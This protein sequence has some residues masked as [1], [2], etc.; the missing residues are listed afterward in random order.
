LA[1]CRG[2]A[3]GI[4]CTVADGTNLLRRCSTVAGGSLSAAVIT[5]RDSC[6]LQRD[7]QATEKRIQLRKL[8]LHSR[9]VFDATGRLQVATALGQVFGTQLDARFLPSDGAFF[10]APS[11]RA[12][13]A[14]RWRRQVAP[15]SLCG[16]RARL[17]L[18]ID[19][20][21]RLCSSAI[22]ALMLVSSSAIS[23]LRNAQERLRAALRR[24]RRTLLGRKVRGQPP[25]KYL[26]QR[27][28]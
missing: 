14:L 27:F 17:C 16:A 23:P 9:L 2:C 15:P 8:S 26:Q 22:R 28:Q 18:S 7:Q 20:S 24:I 1:V 21:K 6:S 11:T 4:L 19:S 12:R 10:P 25:P 3:G 5:H 13:S